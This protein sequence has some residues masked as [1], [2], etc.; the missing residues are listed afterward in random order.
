MPRTMNDNGLDLR[1]HLAEP[2]RFPA[3]GACLVAGCP[4]K[5]PRIVSHH[6]A[7]FFAAVARAHGET[8]N[9]TVAAEAGWQIPALTF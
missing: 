7:A 4:C 2:R 9:R 5:D 8:A 1:Q 3:D 6:R